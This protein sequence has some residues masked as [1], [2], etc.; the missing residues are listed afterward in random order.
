MAWKLIGQFVEFGQG[1][2]GIDCHTVDKVG[3]VDM[4]DKFEMVGIEQ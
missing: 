1:N 4:V 3:I 2:M